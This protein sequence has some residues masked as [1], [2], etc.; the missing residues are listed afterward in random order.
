MKMTIAAEW[1]GSEEGGPGDMG[2][3]MVACMQSRM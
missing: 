1:E 3:H 2:L